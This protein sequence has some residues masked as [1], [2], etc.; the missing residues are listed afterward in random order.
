MLMK[1]EDN[2]FYSDWAS[3]QTMLSCATPGDSIVLK[4]TFLRLRIFTS[5]YFVQIESKNYMGS[6]ELF[7]FL[8]HA[9][10]YF[11]NV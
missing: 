2:L 8:L 6:Y 1:K 5:F 11:T 9:A 4:E 10:L 7:S 3:G